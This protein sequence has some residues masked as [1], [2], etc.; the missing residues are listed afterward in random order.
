MCVLEGDLV[1]VA[2]QRLP[3]RREF[4]R[5][6]QGPGSAGLL[7]ASAREATTNECYAASK[8]DNERA[9]ANGDKL[10]IQYDV[11]ATSA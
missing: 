4:Q 2:G 3:Q 10:T 5:D 6:L 1:A 7:T 8:F 9:L 11:N